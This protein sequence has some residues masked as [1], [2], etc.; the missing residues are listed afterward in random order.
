M[1]LSAMLV[2]VDLPIEINESWYVV[3]GFYP[4]LLVGF[5]EHSEI[6]FPGTGPA[7]VGRER[8]P[9]VRIDRQ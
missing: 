2:P 4:F 8:Q 6:Q 7:A 9:I 1:D 3:F 5:L